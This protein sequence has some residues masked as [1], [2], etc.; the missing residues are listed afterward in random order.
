[1]SSEQKKPQKVIPIK[2]ESQEKSVSFYEAHKK[3]Y[4]RSISGTFM[5]WRWLMVWATQLLF[6]GLPWL[7]W[8]QRQMVLFDLGARRFYLFGYVLYPQDFIYLTGLLIISALALFL[9]TAVAGR[10]WCG[11][12]CPQTVYTEIFMWIEHKVEGDRSARIRLDQAGWT[13]EKVWK[14]SLK[15][16]LWVVFALWTGFTFVGYFVPIRELG[17]ELLALQGGWQIFWVLFYG[18]ATYGNAGYMREQVCK[19]M[20][21]YARFQSAMFDKDTLVVSYD[22]VRGEARG[23]RKKD[24]D[25]K[26]QGLG[27]CIDCKLCVQVCPVGIDIRNGLQYEC[28][29]CG[30]CIDACNNVM[31]NM[32]YPR[33]LIRLT[34]QNAVT[35][36]WQRSQILRRIARPRV[37]IYGAVLVGLS[38]A[39]VVSMALRE[40]LKVDVIRDRASLA[41]IVAG[42]KLENVYRLQVMNATEATQTYHV[43]VHGL[44]GIELVEGG[45]VEVLPAQTRGVAVRVQIPYGA[46]EPGSHHI[47]FD[48]DA[49]SGEGRV[50]EKSVFLVPR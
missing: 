50:S 7:D 40:P 45:E 15:Q 47:V 32:H 17:S 21:P 20:C 16:L 46:A 23:P 3:I 38:V 33:G 30:L 22:T 5:R 44:N 8:G 2:A 12:T 31:D 49:R 25:Y 29:G 35:Q 10:L 37:L 13:W 28:I 6:Y 48:I 14:K 19:Y 18:F 11:F 9:F 42:G 41:R 34:T 26:A 43:Q 24:A 39:M 4:P 1:M 27:D 36:R